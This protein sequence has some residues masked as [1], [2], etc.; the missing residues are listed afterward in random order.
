M[1]TASKVPT[2]PT[3]EEEK[4][5]DRD[6]SNSFN[7]RMGDGSSSP[8]SVVGSGG[9]QIAI[10]DHGNAGGSK[11][12]ND[13]DGSKNNSNGKF[14][15]DENI[16]KVEF[17]MKIDDPPN[18][19]LLANVWKFYKD[20]NDIWTKPWSTVVKMIRSHGWCNDEI[21]VKSVAYFIYQHNVDELRERKRT[22]T[23]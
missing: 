21:M 11:S 7:N 3:L 12:S 22:K 20:D 14:R 1:P 19:I 18:D 4:G 6:R 2:A 15:W 9:L 5:G 23:Q 8:T 16:E 17:D 10:S 13:A